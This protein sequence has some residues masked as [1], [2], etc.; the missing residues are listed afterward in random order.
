[1]VF[2]H[3]GRG[4]DAS[5]AAE[6]PSGLGERLRELVDDEHGF[7]RHLHHWYDIGDDPTDAPGEMTDERYHELQRHLGI[8]HFVGERHFFHSDDMNKENEG[9]EHEQSIVWRRSRHMRPF[10]DLNQSNLPQ[11]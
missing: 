7:R 4:Y 3:A 10:E 1:M 6:Q 11:G 2:D 9:Y 5:A 8:Q